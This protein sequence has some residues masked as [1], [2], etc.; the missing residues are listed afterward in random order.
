MGVG[1]KRKQRKGWNGESTSVSGG[2]EGGGRE[3]YGDG[4]VKGEEGRGV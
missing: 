2:E 1:G 3:W 4:S